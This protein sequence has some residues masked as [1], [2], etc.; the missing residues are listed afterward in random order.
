MGIFAK[1]FA[2][3][4]GPGT[5]PDF[6][7]VM[8]GLDAA[9][10]TTILYKLKLGEVIKTVPTIGFNVETVTYKKIK[11]SV[12]DVGGQDKIRG[13]W[14]HYYKDSKALVFVVDSNDKERMGEAAD[15]FKKLL[16]EEE[17]RDA[18]VLVLANKN[19]LPH[20]VPVAEILE[21]F[22]LEGIKDR[23]WHLQSCCASSGAGLE[24]GFTWLRD[25]LV[26]K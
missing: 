6:R 5:L 18:K 19:D 7:T 14:K 16:L 10:K 9:G 2:R 11:F 8:L 4:P 20:A 13:L 26:Q 21:K 24:D 17:L 12:W 1:L 15:E 25:A 23:K 3:I 22:G